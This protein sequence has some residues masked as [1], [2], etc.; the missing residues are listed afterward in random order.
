MTQKPPGYAAANARDLVTKTDLDTKVNGLVYNVK[1][2]GAVGNGTTDD[3][4]ALTAAIA[5]SSGK[6]IYLPPGTYVTSGLTLGPNRSLVGAGVGLTTLKLKSG[7][8][9]TLL[10]LLDA[11]DSLLTDM[12]LDGNKA[13][14]TGSGETSVLKIDTAPGNLLSSFHLT[15]DRLVILNGANNGLTILGKDNP[16]KVGNAGNWYNWV[17]QCSN[18]DIYQCDSYG[19]FDESS[20]NRFSNFYLTENSKADIFLQGASGNLYSNFKVAEGGLTHVTSPPTKSDGA[21]MIIESCSML[22][23]SNIEIQSGFWDGLYAKDCRNLQFNGVDS[24]NNDNWGYYF[25]NCRGI[26]GIATV[27]VSSTLFNATGDFYFDASCSDIDLK[28]NPPVVGGAPAIRVTNLGAITNI[29]RQGGGSW[30][31]P[32]IVAF[33]SSGTWTKP[34]GAKLVEVV[35]QAGGNAGASGRR[36]AAGTVRCGGGGGGGGGM[37]RITVDPADLPATVAVTVGSGGTG[38]T[39]V[40]ANDTDGNAGGVGTA[41]QFSTYASAS[42]GGAA[43]GGTAASGTGG[44][45]GAASVAGGAGGTASTTGLVGGGAAGTAGAAGGGGSGGGISSANVAANGGT[46]ATSRTVIGVVGGAAGVVDTTNPTTPTA[47]TLKGAPGA[48]GGGGAASIT[49]AAQAGATGAG[50]GGGG[51]GGGASLN[52]DNSGAGGNG[53]P[54]YALIITTF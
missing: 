11:H 48:G 38:G 29:V 28:T 15:V 39:A 4:A 34:T 54:G 27:T 16:T 2:Y 52:G 22:L 40:T 46:G 30:P 44:T 7:S 43:G 49:T 42:V 33:T 12:T 17:L 26:I 8:N 35:L 51:G 18:I 1:D 50:Y 31:A 9:S 14:N 36:G 41:T 3:T 20:D 23:M 32:Q 25:A 47:P 13:A 21:C 53:A 24:Q 45:G 19:L 10:T 6:R 37:T 5:A